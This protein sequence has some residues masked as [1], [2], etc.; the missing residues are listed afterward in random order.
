MRGFLALPLLLCL[1]ATPVL[2]M[3]GMKSQ[4]PG[5]DAAMMEAAIKAFD[6]AD[7][8]KDEA[9]SKDEFL[10]TFS[11]MKEEAFTTIDTNQDG[12]ISKEEW[13]GFAI[14]HSM[15]RSSQGGGM[16]SMP[17][18]PRPGAKGLPTVTPPSG[19]TPAASRGLPMVTPPEG[20]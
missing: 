14:G 13:Q 9:L 20:K 7:A 18:A 2:A 1:M 11:T 5:G 19:E 4:A 15:G 16:G 8:N 12:A 10:T 6:K 3:P 17:P